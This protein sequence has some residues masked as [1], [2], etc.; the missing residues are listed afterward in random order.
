[1]TDDQDNITDNGEWETQT[2]KKKRKSTRKA[3]EAAWQVRERVRRRV[4][5]GHTLEDMLTLEQTTHSYNDR[6][7]EFLNCYADGQ[8]PGNDAK[9][10]PRMLKDDVSQPKFKPAGVRMR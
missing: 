4:I 5:S 10:F 3:L 8:L 6:R 9:V 2:K 1:M 7:A